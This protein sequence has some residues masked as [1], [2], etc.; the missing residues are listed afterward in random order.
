MSPLRAL[1]PENLSTAQRVRLAGF[2]LVVGHAMLIGWALLRAWFYADDF[3][4]LEEAQDH[5]MTADFLFTPHDSQLMPVGRALTWVVAHGGAYNWT[6]AASITLALQ[7][8]AAL[9]CLFMLRTMFGDRWGILV[10]LAL[11]VLSPM[12][13]EAKLWWSAAL[14]AVPIQLAFFLLVA[15]L[16]RWSRDRTARAA[17]MCAVSLALAVLSG[18]RGLVVLVPAGLLLMLFLTP[19]KWWTRPWNVVRVHAVLLVPLGALGI[20]YLVAYAASTPSPVTT[21]GS[22]PALAIV[23]KLVGTS[24]LTTAVGGPWDWVQNNPPLSRPNPPLVLHIT[25]AV[26]V[27]AAVGS[28]LWKRTAP[29]LAA[30]AILTA[31]LAVTCVALIFGRGVQL[32]SDVGL[33]SRYLADALPVTALALGLAMMPMAGSTLPLRHIRV[34]NRRLLV[35]AGGGVAFVVGSL[36]STVAYADAWHRH[37]PARSF[38]ST[39][40]ASLANDPGVIADV[41]VP[42][43]VRTSLSNPGHL[44]SH[45]FSP[46]GDDVRTATRGND[47]RILDANGLQR[48]AM[49]AA[50]TGAAPGP[51]PDCGYR[52]R[53][54]PVEIS[55]DRDKVI[56]FWWLSLGYLASGDGQV[57]IEVD[58]R[59]LSTMTVEEGLHTYFVNGE[60]PYSTVT[61]KA[62]TPGLTMCVDPL[63]TGNL[64]PVP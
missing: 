40:R 37:D 3:Q 22:S 49:V 8:A 64:V 5:R 6:L 44:P 25:A 4:F 1:V 21:E 59:A 55:V 58:G 30:L 31:Q 60:R 20:A 23:R 2:G 63:R 17:L 52:V 50:S 33:S 43:S 28:L 51:V 27:V 15:Y 32:G 7:V 24:W 56:P 10:P 11:Y 53:G 54:E 46:L 12:G 42:E 35:M 39:A 62:V 16:V 9:A 41:G 19:G 61:L 47:L 45:L 18:P 48:P 36:V 38:I 26:V 34:T 29:V 57:E 14:N 13:I